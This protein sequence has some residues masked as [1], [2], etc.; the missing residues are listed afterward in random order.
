MRPKYTPSGPESPVKQGTQREALGLS[1]SHISSTHPVPAASYVEYAARGSYIKLR[2]KHL[3]TD[4]ERESFAKDKARRTVLEGRDHTLEG[5]TPNGALLF[6]RKPKRRAIGGFSP[7][8]QRRLRVLTNSLPDTL[9]LPLFATLTYPEAWPGNP[10]EW[11]RQL[12]LMLTMITRKHGAPVIIWKL[13]PQERGAPHFHLAIYTADFMGPRWLARKWFKIVGSGD[14]KH[15]EAGTSVERARSRRGSLSYMAKYIGK[16]FAAPAGW[17]S[18]GRYWGVRNRPKGMLTRVWV[19]Q[20]SAYRIRRVLWSYRAS[21]N[22]RYKRT[23]YRGDA[24]GTS[25]YLA[26]DLAARVVAYGLGAGD[27]SGDCCGPPGLALV[28]SAAGRYATRIA[29][30]AEAG[31]P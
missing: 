4:R 22:R 2:F 31:A 24:Q 17:E 15:L 29:A 11:K 9:P 20:A 8:S 14:R 3:H 16:A 10:R 28:D 1:Y 18:Q 19:P 6:G 23:P 25:A 5:P 12:D 13:E 27:R 26:G 30:Q 21:H 7:S